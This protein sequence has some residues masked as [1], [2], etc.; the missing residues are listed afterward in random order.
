MG[1]ERAEEGKGS[2]GISYISHRS[3][4]AAG[5]AE[6]ERALVSRRAKKAKAKPEPCRLR[7]QLFFPPP[8]GPINPTGAIVPKSRRKRLHSIP[9]TSS[10]PQPAYH[11][12]TP[13]CVQPPFSERKQNIMSSGVKPSVNSPHHRL[14]S[15]LPATYYSRCTPEEWRLQR[16]PLRKKKHFPPS[17]HGR[18]GA[19]HA[20]AAS[21]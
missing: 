17:T 18:I 16:A 19:S 21:N 1:A 20:S 10:A 8:P 3:G 5:E 13:S 2:R 15:A 12:L 4:D 6:W 14:P 9:R 11:T 7:S